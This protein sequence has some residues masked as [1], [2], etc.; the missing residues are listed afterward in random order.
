M[1]L[2]PR[3][4]STLITCSSAPILPQLI[5][6]TGIQ[7]KRALVRIF[8][9]LQRGI[10]PEISLPPKLRSTNKRTRIRLGLSVVGY[11]RGQVAHYRLSRPFWRGSLYLLY[12]RRSKSR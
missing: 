8:S 11:F 7:R 6:A 5:P 9:L 12:H 2:S 3:F 1:W 4:L 10:L